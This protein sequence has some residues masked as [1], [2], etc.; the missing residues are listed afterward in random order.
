MVKPTSPTS[1]LRDLPVPSS[2]Y[3]VPTETPSSPSLSFPHTP[4]PFS[5][6][7]NF[8][9]TP[10]GHAAPFQR[11]L[12]EVFES[13]DPEMDYSS[14]L[15]PKNDREAQ[16][17]KIRLKAAKKRLAT[18]RSMQ[19]GQH[20]PSEAVL[21]DIPDLEPVTVIQRPAVATSE[22]I[23]LPDSSDEDTSD[24]TSSKSLQEWWSLQEAAEEV[25]DILL[26]ILSDRGLQW[27]DLVNYISDPCSKRGTLRYYGFFAKAHTV[28]AV[29][30]NWVSWENR[31]GRKIIHDWALQYIVR[32]V[33]QEGNAATRDGFLQSSK[34]VIDET[35]A[36]AFD[37]NALYAKISALCPSM[38]TILHAFSTTTRQTKQGTEVDIACKQKVSIRGHINSKQTF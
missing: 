3:P 12:F 10:V 13:S 1:G 8:P 30:D 2:P 7:S 32:T 9:R 27:G 25:L 35:F 38:T 23:V 4:G 22:S 36:L 21:D 20:E 6:S 19:D 24:G 33:N 18:L 17:K 31:G 11:P 37:L 5:P 34:M 26:P 29:L 15:P 14:P 28:R 16:L